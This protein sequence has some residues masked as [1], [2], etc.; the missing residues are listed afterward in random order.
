VTGRVALVEVDLVGLDEVLLA[1]QRGVVVDF[2]GTWCQPC[3][4]LRP[5]LEQLAGDHRDRWRFVAVH[6]D[7]QLDLAT[8]YRVMSTPTIVFIKD[9]D[10][11]ERLS[12][13]A[14]PSAITEILTRRS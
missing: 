14:T 8:K 6:T 2:W 10:E 12:G 5:H 3:R 9:G 7:E 4:T 1:E 11:V 13:S